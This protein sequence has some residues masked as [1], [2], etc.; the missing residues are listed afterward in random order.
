M[1][2]GALGQDSFHPINDPKCQMDD[3]LKLKGRAEGEAGEDEAEPPT[4]ALSER[5]RQRNH[6]RNRQPPIA[7]GVPSTRGW[8]GT[9]DQIAGVWGQSPRGSTQDNSAARKVTTLKASSP[10][11]QQPE[12]PTTNP[13]AC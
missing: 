6:Q 1:L 8:R 5:S 2:Q 7:T 9:P 11:S 12:K 4:H 13:R 10:Q 3:H